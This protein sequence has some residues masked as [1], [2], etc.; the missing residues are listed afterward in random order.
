MPRVG[1][2]EDDLKAHRAALEAR[3]EQPGVANRMSRRVLRELVEVC[4]V[5]G[6]ITDVPKARA[7]IAEWRDFASKT[8]A[9]AAPVFAAAADQLERTVNA[10]AAPGLNR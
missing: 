10:A 7:R 5:D 1:Q 8:N 2:D 6:N 3:R 9:F 4:D